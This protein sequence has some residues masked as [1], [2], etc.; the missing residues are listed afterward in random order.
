MLSVVS[1]VSDDVCYWL[2]SYIGRGKPHGSAL[3]GHRSIGRLPAK[4]KA[5]SSRPMSSWLGQ[6]LL[7]VWESPC[8]GKIHCAVTLKQEEKII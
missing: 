6:R 8:L 4:T 5:S 3:E 1:D 7:A 2:S